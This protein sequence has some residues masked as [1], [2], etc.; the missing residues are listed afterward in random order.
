MAPAFHIPVA[1][2]RN[3]VVLVGSFKP[4][5]DCWQL[6]V[7]GMQSL[8]WVSFYPRTARGCLSTVVGL[9]NAGL[10]LPPTVFSSPVRTTCSRTLCSL[11]STEH[12]QEVQPVVGKPVP[13][14]KNRWTGIVGQGRA[15]RQ[16][17]VVAGALLCAC[18]VV[19]LLRADLPNVS[20]GPT[21][22]S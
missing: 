5:G 11:S 17:V 8:P 1:G 6:W 21:A 7:S 16:V 13:E 20:L 2:L 22:P 9:R 18:L 19:A 12:T 10:P 14:P 3:V 15:G 4:V